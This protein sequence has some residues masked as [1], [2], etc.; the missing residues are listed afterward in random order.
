[1]PQG[2]VIYCFPCYV[3]AF[4]TPDIFFQSNE[5]EKIMILAPSSSETLNYVVWLVRSSLQ[6]EGGGTLSFVRV[7]SF[8]CQ[9][10]ESRLWI[11]RHNGLQ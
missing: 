6:Q 1:V 7:V 3:I 11:T 5:K 10:G 2:V 4:A 9:V 8:S